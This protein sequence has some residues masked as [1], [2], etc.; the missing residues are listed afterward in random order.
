MRIPAAIEKLRTYDSALSRNLAGALQRAV[1]DRLDDSERALRDRIEALRSELA[2]RTD[3]IDPDKHPELTV[4][5]ATV[6]ASK[7]PEDAL[8]LCL[9]VRAAQPQICLEMGTNV[10]ISAAY[11]AGALKLNGSGSLLCLE[12]SAGRAAVTRSTLE[13]LGLDDVQIEI[14]LFA[15]TLD[16]AL[17]RLGALDY[18]F[19]DGHHQEQPTI[20]YFESISRVIRR[21]GYAVFDDIGWSEGM[22]RAWAMIA[23]DSRV[24]FSLR[25]ERIGLCLFE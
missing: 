17:E 15:H 9:M 1:K 23:A 16:P 25:L 21:P 5:E 20:R 6:K 7:R 22:E 13:R 14:G 3:K 11:Q 2:G 24:S 10:G 18:V 8:M 4:G 12:G 19:V